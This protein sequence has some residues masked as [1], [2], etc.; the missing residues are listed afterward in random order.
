[1]RIGMRRI[2]MSVAGTTIVA[3]GVGILRFAAWGVDPFTGLMTGLDKLVPLSYGALYA[4]AN[5]VLLAFAL[6]TERRYIGLGTLMNLL[7][8]GYLAELTRSLLLRLL[9]EAA[10][11]LCFAMLL[12]GILVQCFG[13]ALYM[14]ADLGV[15]AY[16]AV[17]LVLA[18][19]RRIWK[20]R[21]LRVCTDFVCV[22]VGAG[23]FL[24]GG[25]TVA[26]IPAFIGPGTIITAFFMGPAI[27]F[28]N[29]TVAEPLISKSER[30]KL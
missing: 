16:D 18:N 20:F 23:L 9:P 15:S 12:A 8:T 2:L 11:W 29:R 21:Y 25:G 4:A 17:A 19:K 5:G 28:F 26:G 3:L 7:F 30:S 1:M 14:S 13:S 24:L 10:P 27:D 6:V 22:A